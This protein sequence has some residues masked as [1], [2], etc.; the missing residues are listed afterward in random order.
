MAPDQVGRGK[1]VFHVL[2]ENEIGVYEHFGK[3]FNI[4]MGRKMGL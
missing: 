2:R 3:A 4:G 1:R